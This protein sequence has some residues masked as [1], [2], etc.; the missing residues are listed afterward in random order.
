[1]NTYKLQT[2]VLR[3]DIFNAKHVKSTFNIVDK[4]NK[5]HFRV[6]AELYDLKRERVLTDQEGKPTMG[7]RY[8]PD[9]FNYSTVLSISVKQKV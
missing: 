8:I 5:F 7:L 2:I 4:R 6:E 1:M 3:R 9:K